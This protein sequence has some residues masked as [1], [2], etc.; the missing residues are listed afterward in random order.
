MGESCCINGSI[1][2]RYIR[3]YLSNPALRWL[4]GEIVIGTPNAPNVF[5]LSQS[6]V[7]SQSGQPDFTY[8]AFDHVEAGKICGFGIRYDDARR[9][10]DAAGLPHANI[11]W[12]KIVNNYDELLAREAQY[13]EEGYEGLM[14][15]DPLGKYKFGR[16]TQREQGLL[17]MKRFTDDEGIITGYEPLLRNQNDPMIDALGLQ[18]RGYSKDGKVIDDTRIG[19]FLGIGVP[20]SRWAG[21]PFS[22]GSGLTDDDRVKYRTIINQLIAQRTQF[23]YKYQAHGSLE[24]PRM[25]I[26]KGL[27]LDHL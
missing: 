21:V 9:T 25:P 11:L 19:K 6:G 23:S 12:H 7:M 17:K 5:N 13:V 20:N 14:I 27:R 8:Y 18:K 10:I 22:I 15:R 26:F 2:N 4:D 24:A 3:D 16:S 1:P